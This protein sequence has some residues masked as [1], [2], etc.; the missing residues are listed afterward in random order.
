MCPVFSARNRATGFW[1]T[2][3]VAALAAIVIAFATQGAQ[4]GIITVKRCCFLVKTTVK[5]TISVDFGRDQSAYLSGKRDFTWS[6]TVVGKY[7]Y[8]N[9]RRP[10][11]AAPQ[12]E[13]VGQSR[14]KF[15]TSEIGDITVNPD[16]PDPPRPERVS[17]HQCEEQVTSGGR[18]LPIPGQYGQVVSLKRRQKQVL[19]RI[20]LPGPPFRLP[21]TV[22]DGDCRGEIYSHH[23]EADSDGLPLVRFNRL[24]PPGPMDRLRATSVRRLK[25]LG[26]FGKTYTFRVRHRRQRD[27]QNARYHVTFG[28]NT[29]EVV[30]RYVEG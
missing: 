26:D 15:G 6:A 23:D 4:G 3:A 17:V 22:F 28:R 5:G 20:L 2:I 19:M 13:S 10:F 29:L 16:S 27:P 14:A 11:R 8:L 7:R 9:R 1:L 12:L 30:F 18:W 25:E 21:G 24:G